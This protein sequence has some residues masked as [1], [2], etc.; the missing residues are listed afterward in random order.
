MTRP[1]AEGRPAPKFRNRNAADVGRNI[2]PH[3]RRAPRAL[4]VAILRL[5]AKAAATISPLALP[6]AE[7]AMTFHSRMASTRQAATITRW[8]YIDNAKAASSSIRQV[9]DRQ[10]HFV[11]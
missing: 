5:A 7:R 6:R 4:R 11:V 3:R 1:S 2:G 9:L 10:L 8:V